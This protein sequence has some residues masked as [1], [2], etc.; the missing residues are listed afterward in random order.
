[1]SVHLFLVVLRMAGTI[2]VL[3]IPCGGPYGMWCLQ[4]S[5]GYVFVFYGR[6]RTI[7]SRV[8]SVNMS[9]IEVNRQIFNFGTR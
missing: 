6:P 1:M 7:S 5:K 8:R 3:M 9:R 2:L 4:H